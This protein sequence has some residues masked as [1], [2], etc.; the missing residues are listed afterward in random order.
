MYTSIMKI[1]AESLLE[2]YSKNDLT[3]VELLRRTIEE[4]TITDLEL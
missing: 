1:A 2:R 4:E 3:T